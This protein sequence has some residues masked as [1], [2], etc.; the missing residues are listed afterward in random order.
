MTYRTAYVPRS[1]DPIRNEVPFDFRDDPGREFDAGCVVIQSL[2]PRGFSTES[3]TWRFYLC[4]HPH[5]SSTESQMPP[6][7]FEIMRDRLAA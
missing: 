3:N 5:C 6:L 7:R 1:L 4:L 2:K